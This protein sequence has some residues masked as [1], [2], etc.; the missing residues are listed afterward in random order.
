MVII[1]EPH[2]KSIYGGTLA[3]PVF[4]RV[5]ERSLR[6]LATKSQLGVGKNREPMMIPNAPIEIRDE[7]LFN[8]SYHHG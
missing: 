5:M 1:D 3:A 4:R 8:A 6:F 2:A 7:E